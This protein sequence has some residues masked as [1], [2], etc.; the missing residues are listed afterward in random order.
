MI[1]HT[2]IKHKKRITEKSIFK[3]KLFTKINK[4]KQAHLLGHSGLHK[5]RN[6]TCRWARME[7]LKGQV[8]PQG[9]KEHV[10]PVSLLWRGDRESYRTGAYKTMR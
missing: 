3:V 6:P 5:T 9:C 2:N 4:E 8:G 7:A 10:D 1:K